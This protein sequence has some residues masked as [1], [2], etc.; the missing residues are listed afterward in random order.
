MNAAAME[1]LKAAAERKKAN[2]KDPVVKSLKVTKEQYLQEKAEEEAKKNKKKNFLSSASEPAADDAALQRILQQVQQERNLFVKEKVAMMQSMQDMRSEMVQLKSQMMNSSAEDKPP[3]V[4]PP[5]PPSSHSSDVTDSLEQELDATKDR[6]TA[7]EA[8]NTKLRSQ[9][10]KSLEK[11]EEMERDVSRAAPPTGDQSTEELARLERL[12][13]DIERRQTEMQHKVAATQNNDQTEIREQIESMEKKVA[14]LDLA[15]KKK[16][17]SKTPAKER[18]VAKE[19]VDK[20]ESELEKIARSKTPTKRREVADELPVVSPTTSKKNSVSSELSSPK[21]LE[22]DSVAP[23]PSAPKTPKTPKTPKKSSAKS[24][25]PKG[26]PTPP[27]GSNEAIVPH[28]ASSLAK[29]QARDEKLMDFLEKSGGGAMYPKFSMSVKMI[30]GYKIVHFYKKV[31]IPASLVDR[32]LE[33]YRDTHG[34]NWTR[35]LTKQVIWPSLDADVTDF[36]HKR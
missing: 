33:Y 1:M 21:T 32:T 18:S 27:V 3:V 2:W 19:T 8:E 25:S 10:S 29:A 36:K 14:M 4:A 17:R 9:I 28:A 35:V 16:G 24:L 31:Y 7:L 23:K 26:S 12:V 15:V 20:E 6:V 34:E 13:Q 11:L 5:P 22:K 30:D